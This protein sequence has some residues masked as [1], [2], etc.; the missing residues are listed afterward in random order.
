VKGFWAT[1]R[2]ATAAKGEIAGL[3]GELV[4]RAASGELVLPVDEKFELARVREAMTACDRPGR[5]G[6][7]VLVSST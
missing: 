7:I 6:K 1:R 3:I 4:K 5:T 2:S